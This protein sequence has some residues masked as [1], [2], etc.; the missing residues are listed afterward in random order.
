MSFLRKLLGIDELLDKVN[1]LEQKSQQNSLHRKIDNIDDDLLESRAELLKKIDNLQNKLLSNECQIKENKQYNKL[2]FFDPI[3]NNCLISLEFMQNYPKK[4]L[5]NPISNGA[6]LSNLI[7]AFPIVQIAKQNQLL[8][9]A[10]RVIIPEGAAGRLMQYKNGL[11]GTPLVGANGKITAHAGLE[12]IQGISMNPALIFT[13]MSFFTGQYFMAQI[14]KSLKD[15][16]KN[17]EGIRRMILDDKISRNFAIYEFYQEISSNI[18]MILEH[19]DLRISYLTNVQNTF[20][21]LRQNISFFEKRI[22]ENIQDLKENFEGGNTT[23]KRIYS[24]N[25]EFSKIQEF[26]EQRLMCLL[27]Y[28]QGKILEIQLAKIYDIEYIEKTIDDLKSFERRVNNYMIRTQFS[29][30]FNERIANKNIIWNEKDLR[31]KKNE[32][33]GR[34]DSLKKQ[35]DNNYKSTLQGMNNFLE[36][37]KRKNEFIICGDNLYLVSE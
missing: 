17:L 25:E 36:F 4:D 12:K 9:G 15:I 11:L 13:T 34:M 8:E 14:N 2:E 23:N 20:L 10:Y 26:I 6:K 35:F 16:S 37:N 19:D 28:M 27:L 7:Q 31:E 30:L 33:L 29:N 22:N 3:N 5:K 24:L 32:I 21:D 18:E 1:N